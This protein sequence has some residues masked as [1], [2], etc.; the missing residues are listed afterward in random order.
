MIVIVLDMTLSTNR[1]RVVMWI[2]WPL[3][4]IAGGAAIPSVLRGVLG[5]GVYWSWAP[6]HLMPTVLAMLIGPI[7]LEIWL[8]KGRNNG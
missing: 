3:L 7:L 4:L 8:R 2:G 6:R 5:W 1:M